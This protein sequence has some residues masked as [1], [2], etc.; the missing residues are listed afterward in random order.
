MADPRA[1]LNELNLEFPDERHVIVALNGRNASRPLPFVDP[2]TAADH[3]DLRWYL[4]VYGAHSLGDPDDNRARIIVSRLPELG[5]ALFRAALGDP[6]AQLR[7]NQFLLR[8]EGTRL[9]TVSAEHPA[10]LALPWELLHGPIAGSVPLFLE[11]PS[12]SIR[13]RVLGVSDGREPFPVTAKNTLRLLFI[14]SRPDDAGFLDPRADTSPILDAIDEHAPGRVV[15]EFLRPPTLDALLTRL[16]DMNRPPI[17][18]L[19]FDGHGVFDHD[20]DLPRRLKDARFRRSARIEDIL[21]DEKHRKF[22]APTDPDA[23][24]NMGYLLF[25]DRDHRA[26]L[27]SS[28]KLGENLHR[29]KIALTILSACQSAAIGSSAATDASDD[30]AIRGAMGSVAARL[31]ATGIPSVLAMTHAV[32]IHTTRALF[33][34]FYREL[35]THRAVGA[36]LDAARRH[37]LNHPERYEVQ[38]DPQPVPLRLHDWFLPALYQPGDDGPLLAAKR[39]TA[40]PAVPHT[41]VPPAPEAGFFGRK[42]DLWDIERWFADGTR[43]ITLT[44]FGGQGKTA[45]AQEAARWLVRTSMFAAA[46]FVDYAAIQALDAVAVAVRNIGSVLGETL[47]D[48]DATAEALHRTPTLVILDNL[49]ALPPEALRE[50]LDAAVRWSAAGSSR[51]LCTTRRPTFDHADYRVEGTLIHRR[52]Q[53]T[54]LGNREAPDDSLEWFAELMRLPPAPLYLTKRESLIELFALV[55]F[56]PLSIR[57]LSQQLRTRRPADLGSRL[58]QRL[59]IPHPHASPETPPELLACLQ[60]S[61]ERLD[62][63]ARRALPSLGVFQG[64]AFEDDL[65]AITGLGDLGERAQREQ[66]LADIERGDVRAVLRAVGQLGDAEVPPELLANMEAQ[67][68]QLAERLR[69]ELARRPAPSADAWPSLRRQLQAAALFEPEAIPGVLFPFLRFHP[70]LAPMMWAELGEEDRTRL[71]VAHR[72]RYY[73]LSRFLYQNDSRRV[74]QARAIA[75]R[76]LPN[77]LHA[78]H[79][80]L[81]ASDPDAADFVDKVNSFLVTFSLGQEAASL[82]KK[83]EATL[84][85]DYLVQSNLGEHL[86]NEGK[87][88]AEDVFQAILKRLGEAPTHER[89]ATLGR[90]GRCFK[91]RNLLKQAAQIFQDSIVVCDQLQPNADVRRHRAAMLTDLADTLATRGRFAEARE[92]YE[93]SLKVAEELGDL[94]MQGILLAQLGS[95]AA[96][97]GDHGDAIKRYHAALPLFRGLNEPLTESSLLHQLGVVYQAT[98]AWDEAEQHCREAARIKEALGVISGPHGAIQTWNQLGI[99]N[100]LAGRPLA[101]EDW[102]RKALT[103]SPLGSSYSAF[104]LNNLASL[105]QTQPG[106]L[107]EARKFAEESLDIK[108]TLDPDAAEIWMTYSILADIA[109]R[110]ADSTEDAVHK[111]KLCDESS[112]FRRQARDAMRAFAG[113]RHELR[114]FLTLIA[115]TIEVVHDASRRS[116]LEQILSTMEQKGWTKL[117]AAIRQLLAGERD[118]GALCDGLDAQ[119]SMILETILHGLADPTCLADLQPPPASDPT[120]DT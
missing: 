45:L 12:I 30:A 46:V 81:D 103:A 119:D 105:L 74:Q 96:R 44:G 33:G 56:H 54:G 116:S 97:E 37:L 8:E 32:L 85:T 62:E 99:L 61:L 90:L 26:D 4:E 17:D 48:A 5:R 112:D 43:R 79:A 95:L 40:P 101:A 10:I 75:L 89:A 59:A 115:G 60:L 88:A 25:E 57:V 107:A 68:P 31:T 71:S 6:E 67:L 118:T 2:L 3:E 110:Q 70:T 98:G 65:V 86:Y 76:E 42:H 24:P 69:A 91:Q 64:G 38:R 18:V 72:K 109:D 77:L 28:K 7:Y 41:N 100:K 35:A 27:V 52:I 58:E 92:K 63:A 22:E 36:A 93:V 1:I 34:V 108:K 114:K 14:V 39:D 49:E 47:L 78:V 80:S 21:R 117:S 20:G 94:R 104:T 23:P 50:L 15:C 113:T 120:E 82:R 87:A 111:Q 84:A 83:A 51:L 73:A 19:H 11:R 66:L 13:R 9:L 55:K 16:D 102:Y 29:R 53:L 106:R